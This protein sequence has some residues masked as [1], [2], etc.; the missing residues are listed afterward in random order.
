M[1]PKE[2][3]EKGAK[4]L[5][6]LG[7]VGMILSMVVPP[8]LIALNNFEIII[9]HLIPGYTFAWVGISLP[10][11]SLLF[12]YLHNKKSKDEEKI[13]FNHYKKNAIEIALPSTIIMILY[14]VI[15]VI[16]FP[17]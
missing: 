15:M 8:T 2:E 4:A 16:L 17:A 13:D 10:M 3:E 12:I 7:L 1:G 11:V 9:D 6:Y 5:N 14:F